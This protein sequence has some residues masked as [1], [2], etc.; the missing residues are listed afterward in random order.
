MPSLETY[1]KVADAHHDSAQTAE[2]LALR[3]LAGINGPNPQHREGELMVDEEGDVWMVNPT[4]FERIRVSTDARYEPVDVDEDELLLSRLRDEMAPVPEPEQLPIPED[5]Q[6]RDTNYFDFSPDAIHGNRRRS[7]DSCRGTLEPSRH[8][9]C[10]MGTVSRRVNDHV[11]A[12]RS[13]TGCEGGETY[14]FID[15]K[16]ITTVRIESDRNLNGGTNVSVYIGR[17]CFSYFYWER[18]KADEFAAFILN[19]KYGAHT[20]NNSCEVFDAE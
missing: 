17:E 16:H 11:I 7:G 5:Y 15:P 6:Y 2:L 1:C 14:T 4:T 3:N 13:D 9:N 12:L 10:Q 19:L 8:N 18:E 20:E